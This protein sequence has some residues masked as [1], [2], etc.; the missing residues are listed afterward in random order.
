LTQEQAQL[1]K[2]SQFFGRLWMA[3]F[4]GAALIAPMLIT[5]Y[6]S[7]HN[8]RICRCGG[9]RS[10]DFHERRRRQRYSGSDR[11]LCCC[12]CGFCG[13]WD[14]YDGLTVRWLDIYL[15]AMWH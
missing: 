7:Y 14:E 2:E 5:K 12:A 1:K 4:G 15:I 10:G 9:S 6:L 11:G 3:L 13:C 8:I